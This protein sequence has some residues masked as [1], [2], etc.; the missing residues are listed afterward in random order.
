[1]KNNYITKQKLLNLNNQFSKVI[2]KSKYLDQNAGDGPQPSHYHC[3]GIHQSAAQFDYILHKVANRVNGCRWSWT[4]LSKTNNKI[5]LDASASG[6][7]EV[8]F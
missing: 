6:L 3:V 2:T 4:L 8:N 1:M 7:A 5:C